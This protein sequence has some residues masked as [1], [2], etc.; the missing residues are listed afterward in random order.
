MEH[1]SSHRHGRP[2]RLPG[3]DYASRGVYFLTLCCWNRQQVFGQWVDDKV[4]LNDWGLAVEDEWLK[5]PLIRPYVRLDEYVIMPDHLHGLVFWDNDSV[6]TVGPQCV[7]G[8]QP[9][10]RRPAA[11]LGSFIARFKAACTKRIN[12][13]RSASVPPIWQNNYFEHIVRNQRSLDRIR[14]YIQENPRRWSLRI[15]A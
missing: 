12:A 11:S 8:S 10:L 4:Q 13:L 15:G 9:A 2:P 14:R 5:T 7:A 6:E 3:Y 1:P